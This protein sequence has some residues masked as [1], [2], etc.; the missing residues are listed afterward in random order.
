MFIS[1]TNGPEKN[2]LLINSMFNDEIQKCETFRKR[3]KS[4]GIYLVFLIWLR[5]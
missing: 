4:S 5:F 2:K 1:K 3:K